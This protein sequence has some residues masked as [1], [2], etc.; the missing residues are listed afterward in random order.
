M[1][2]LEHLRGIGTN[3]HMSSLGSF[4]HFAFRASFKSLNKSCTFPS[5]VS[6]A[7]LGTFTDGQKKSSDF[8]LCQLHQK[9][10]LWNKDMPKKD[11]PVMSDYGLLDIIVDSLKNG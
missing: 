11:K 4:L 3:K 2:I 1:I 6:I 5:S 10:F 9:R 7:H 8:F